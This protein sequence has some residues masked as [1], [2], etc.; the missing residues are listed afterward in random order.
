MTT[1]C[2][3]HIYRSMNGWSVWYS[4]R[5]I[6]RSSHGMGYKTNYPNQMSVQEIYHQP[7]DQQFHHFAYENRLFNPRPKN[8]SGSKGACCP[9]PAWLSGTC[10]LEKSSLH[11]SN[12]NPTFGVHPSNFPG[13]SIQLS[14][15]IHPTFRGRP[16]NFPGS[17]KN[18][19]KL[20]GQ[21]C[22]WKKS[23]TSW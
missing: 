3:G 17:M 13:S 6:Y 15:V 2:G 4:C 5:E 9:C 14:G 7:Q 1:P 22:W 18:E 11:L 21:Y 20:Q 16:S 19:T 12:L 8:L 23:C 10:A